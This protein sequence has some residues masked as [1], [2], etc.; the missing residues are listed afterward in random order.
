MF[1]EIQGNIISDSKPCVC[2]AVRFL[3]AV[4]EYMANK[5]WKITKITFGKYVQT[6]GEYFLSILL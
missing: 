3:Q 6:I 2:S 4:N 1:N 5:G